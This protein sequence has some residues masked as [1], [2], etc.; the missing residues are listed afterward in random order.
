MPFTF[1]TK[2]RIHIFYR[3]I[4]R[5][6]PVI[7]ARVAVTVWRTMIPLPTLNYLIYDNQTRDQCWYIWFR[8]IVCF[9]NTLITCKF[10]VSIWNYV[11]V[12]CLS[13][14]LLIGCLSKANKS[15]SAFSN[16]V[17]FP[18]LMLCSFQVNYYL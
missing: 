3:S 7:Y 4:F 11:N 13:F 6:I 9:L 14:N 17:K 12:T 15:Y 8:Y 18:W 5:V 16:L 2:L 10:L 1:L